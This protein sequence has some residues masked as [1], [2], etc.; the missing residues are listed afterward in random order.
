MIIASVAFTF[1]AC[2]KFE[3]G[4]TATENLAG[5]WTC[6]I[7]QQK[8]D[9]WTAFKEAEFMTYNTSANRGTEMWLDDNENFWKT[10]CKIDCNNSNATFGKEG[11]EYVD[12]YTEVKQK[13]WGGKITKNGAVAP[14]TKSV[15]DKIEFYISF[16][17]DDAGIYYYVV[18]YRLTGYPEDTGDNA[19]IWDWANL[20]FVVAAE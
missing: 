3:A 19:Y 13:I 8:A 2:E 18:G 17:D 5:N 7:Y 14:G 12:I 9:V 1:S 15:C 16:A 10:K 4:G 6:S 11:T 20:S